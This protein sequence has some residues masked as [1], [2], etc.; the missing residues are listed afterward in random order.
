MKNAMSSEGAIDG[1][2][3]SRLPCV[4]WA[5]RGVYETVVKQTCSERPFRFSQLWRPTG[6]ALDGGAQFKWRRSCT[7]DMPFGTLR[8]RREQASTYRLVST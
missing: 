8:F 4:L 3:R 2:L 5:A 6:G 1:T 7:V